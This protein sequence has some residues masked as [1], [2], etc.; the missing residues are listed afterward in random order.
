[1][2]PWG[3]VKFEIRNS[4]FEN[5]SHGSP[6]GSIIAQES[7]PALGRI[8]PQRANSS[9]RLSGV[10]PFSRSPAAVLR[11]TRSSQSGPSGSRNASSRVAAT[12]VSVF[13]PVAAPRP[14]HH[15]ASNSLARVT[16]ERE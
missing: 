11:R 10:I 2:C 15:P 5:C 6:A 1:M 7:Y 13:S 8:C 4:K 16:V 9:A 12:V 14:T 3:E